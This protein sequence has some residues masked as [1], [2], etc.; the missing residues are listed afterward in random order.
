MDEITKLKM[1]VAHLKHV[2]KNL[3][4]ANVPELDYDL[5]EDEFW[6]HVYDDCTGYLSKVKPH[7]RYVDATPFK[8]KKV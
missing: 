1:Q 2:C 6:A 5:G 4:M 8:V 3:G 7:G